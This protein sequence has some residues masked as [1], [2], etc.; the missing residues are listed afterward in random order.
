[1]E[2]LPVINATYDCYK[3]IV[4]MNDHLKKQWRYS[5]GVSLETTILDLA[6]QLIMAKNAPKPLKAGYLIK[7]SSHQ[8]IATLKLRLFLALELVNKTKIFQAQR[9]LAEIG[10]MGLSPNVI[11]A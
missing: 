7:A 4:E 11:L 9:R 5:L 10:K 1:M 2:T 8:E 6:G 3:L